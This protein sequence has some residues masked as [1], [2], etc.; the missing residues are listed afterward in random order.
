[1]SLA[2]SQ[3]TLSLNEFK[4]FDSE[5][6]ATITIVQSSTYKV[7][8]IGEYAL[9]NGIGV[10]VLD[11]TLKIKAIRGDMNFEKTEIRVYTPSMRE[12][13]LAKGGM[14]TM[15]KE[16]S[17]IKDFSVS[18]GEGAKVDLSNIAF[19]NLVANATSGAQIFYKSVRSLVASSNGGAEIKAGNTL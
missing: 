18:A 4:S 13:N 1:M 15:D 10:A 2:F 19:D 6:N 3:R 14:L 17:K 5:I 12:I 11:N 7:E 9:L 8:L 16:F